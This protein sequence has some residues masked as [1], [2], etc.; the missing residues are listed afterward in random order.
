M[1]GSAGA[2]TEKNRRATS[3][4]GLLTRPVDNGHLGLTGAYGSCPEGS[5]TEAVQL[6]THFCG[7]CADAEEALIAAI[8]AITKQKIGRMRS[9]PSDF[10]VAM[11]IVT[12]RYLDPAVSYRGSSAGG[13]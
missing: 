1:P 5:C 9:Q 10:V 11:R 7:D 13:A 2:A 4:P 8:N 6:V 3:A 12:G